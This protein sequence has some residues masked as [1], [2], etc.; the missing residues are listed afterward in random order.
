MDQ[1]LTALNKDIVAWHTKTFPDCTFESQLLKL[2]EEIKEVVASKLE[3]RI[4]TYE[5]IAD[6]YIVS[7]VLAKRYKSAIGKYF[8]SLVQEYPVPNL[9]VRVEKKME[10]NKKRVWVKIKGVYRHK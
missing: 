2:D 3:G 9:A 4:A 5:E 10:I 6:V 1:E 8:V 7:V